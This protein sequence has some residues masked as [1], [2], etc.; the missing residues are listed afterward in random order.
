ML[1]NN[2]RILIIDDETDI[3][4]LY[5][6]ILSYTPRSKD[7]YDLILAPDGEE[8]IQQA[9]K[10]VEQKKPFA[11]A[12]IDMK[13]PG[14]DGAETAKCIWENDP[15]IKIV[16]V[17]AFTEQTTEDIIR[18]TGN[19]DI[20]YLRKPF[21]LE[22]IKQFARVLTK[23][24]N[25]ERERK[26]LARKLAELREREIDTAS[27]IQRTLLLGQP[28]QKIQGIQ[29]EQLSIASQKVDGDFYDFFHLNRRSLDIVVG[30]VMGKGIPAALLGAAAKSHFMNVLNEMIRIDICDDLPEPEKIVS[31][32]HKRI[33]KQVEE[34]ETF[35]TLCYARID[36]VRKQFIFVD[37]GHM[38]TI[39]FHSDLN[40][41]SLL[42]GED[43]PLGFPGQDN[44]KQVSVPFKPD[45]V[46]FFYSDGLI[47]AKNQDGDFY[48]EENLADFI[49]KN[50]RS[51]PKKLINKVWKEIVAFSQSEIFDDDFTCVAGIIKND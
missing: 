19:D 30:D 20:F 39:H 9:K 44:F 25:L 6:D 8:G 12:F 51:G 13:M 28:P 7:F 40:T 18:I 2:N 48:G 5:K 22:E 42:Q 16:I 33:I 35:I 47:E 45:D 21:D 29:L 37:C 11:V 14:I 50:A 3:R 1:Y 15:D 27:K 26:D 49:L 41:V 23:E 34:L 17:T 38:R 36:L 43:M 24:W 32:V 10:A 4:E 46:F 31:S